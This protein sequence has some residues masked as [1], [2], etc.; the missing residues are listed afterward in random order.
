MS[1]IQTT[2]DSIVDQ[3]QA[4][5]TWLLSVLQDIQAKMNYL[6]QEALER[7]SE[8]MKVPMPR[9]AGL[10][11]FYSAFSLKPRGRRV[12]NVC[13]GTACHVRGA[14]LILDTL[15]RKLGIGIDE[16]TSDGE[17]TLLKVGC[18]GACALGPIV[19]VNGEIFGQMTVTKADKLPD[20]LLKE[21]RGGT[22]K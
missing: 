8:R 15:E 13:M 3:Y 1:E 7:V 16:T 4:E 10:A 9:V 17:F 12:I 11:T 21:D 22:E 19:E 20:K 6:P 5:P 2:V 18:L 14:P